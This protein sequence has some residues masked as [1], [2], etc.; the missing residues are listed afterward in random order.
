MR[1]LLSIRSDMSIVEEGPDIIHVN[2]DD[3]FKVRLKESSISVIRLEGSK[4]GD[5]PPSKSRSNPTN[6]GIR[7]HH[8]PK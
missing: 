2:G 7:I 1:R 6:H 8:Q 5:L 4:K 3:I